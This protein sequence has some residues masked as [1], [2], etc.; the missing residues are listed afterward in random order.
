[1]KQYSFFFFKWTEINYKYMLQTTG[2]PKI[3]KKK[4]KRLKETMKQELLEPR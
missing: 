4:K 3:G 1:M 2:P